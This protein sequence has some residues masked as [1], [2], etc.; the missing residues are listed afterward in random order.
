MRAVDADGDG[1][2]TLDE[3]RE[4][5]K[6]IGI[7]VSPVELMPQRSLFGESRR[8]RSA[9]CTCQTALTHAWR[10]HRS[11]IPQALTHPPLAQR[12]H[13][14]VPTSGLLPKPYP[15]PQRR[16]QALP[17]G[18]GRGARPTGVTLLQRSAP[19][20]RRA[21]ARS[22]LRTCARWDRPCVSLPR[23]RAEPRCGPGRSFQAAGRTR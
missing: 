22:Q 19:L 1:H 9:Q 11:M 7:S 13:G 6:R 12:R 10:T 20:L 8:L 15:L 18:R 21:P 17:R 2:L 23:T 16:L 3:F 5:R 14:G 4:F